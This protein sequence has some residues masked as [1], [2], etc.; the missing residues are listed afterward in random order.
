MPPASHR[1]HAIPDGRTAEVSRTA[2]WISPVL[3]VDGRVAGVWEH[4]VRGELATVTV[5]AFA[6]QPTAVRAAAQ[7]CADRYAPLLGVDAVEVGWG[8]GAGA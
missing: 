7:A 5:R 1:T 8:R 3:V 2:G 6:P 4:T